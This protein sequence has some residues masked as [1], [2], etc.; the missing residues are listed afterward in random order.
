MIKGQ[1]TLISN[2]YLVVENKNW[3]QI[4]YV[5]NP[6]Q[7]AFGQKIVLYICQYQNKKYGFKTLRQKKLFNMFLYEKQIAIDIA[8][9]LVKYDFLKS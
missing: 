9:T 1:I 7:F 8:L 5:L 2:S 3:G 6:E 4:V